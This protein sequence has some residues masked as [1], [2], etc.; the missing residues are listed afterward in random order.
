MFVA[1]LILIC[2]LALFLFYLQATCQRILRKEF[3]S[4]YFRSIVAANRLEF[5]AVQQG[6]AEY[7]ASA[8][9]ARFRMTLKCDFLALTYL[10]KHA[11]NA[12]RGYTREERLLL[13]YFQAV[14]LVMTTRHA[15]GLGEKRAFA[16]LA[17]ILQYFANTVGQRVNLVRFGNLAPSNYLLTL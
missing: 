17:T 2:S 4:E 15:L 8:D 14:Y 13:F 10:L 12:G 11:G 16:K 9:Y 6:L 3:D 7:D 1:T 5:P